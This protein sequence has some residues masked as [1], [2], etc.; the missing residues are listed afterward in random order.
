MKADFWAIIGVGV[1]LLGVTLTGQLS[2]KADIAGLHTEVGE[3][4]AEMNDQRRELSGQID[5]LR[6]V[7][8]ETRSSVYELQIT[9]SSLS[10]AVADLEGRVTLIETILDDRLPNAFAEESAAAQG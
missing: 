2:V 3:L 5:A 8:Y 9:V 7:V 4:R 6:E 10:R 1:V